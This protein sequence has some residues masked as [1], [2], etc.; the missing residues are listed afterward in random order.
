MRELKVKQLLAVLLCISGISWAHDDALD[1]G[2]CRDGQVVIVAQINM[3]HKLLSSYKLES[4]NCSPLL[5]Q[6]SCGQFD[7]DYGVGYRAA[8]QMCHQIN[9]MVGLKV[10]LIPLFHGPASFLDEG[11][12]HGVYSISEG[13]SISCAMCVEQ[14]AIKVIR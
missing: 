2:W 5:S 10:E 14:Q 7:D 3:T 12:H 1:G 13:L 11:Q 6:K 8:S 9:P 4:E